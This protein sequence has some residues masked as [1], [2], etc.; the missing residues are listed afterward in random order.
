[1]N[2]KDYLNKVAYVK[3]LD[4][5]NG[6]GDPDF[7]NDCYFSKFDDSYITHVG[8]ED[9]V[10]FLA[11]REITDELTHG[12]GFSPKENKWFGW[13]HRAIYGFEVG[14]TCEK[15]SCH[16]NA[17]NKDDFIESVMA[18]WGDEQYHEREWYEEGT[19]RYK[20][21]E[22]VESPSDG[23]ALVEKPNSTTYGD[24]M[25][26]VWIYSLY[27][28]KV[29]NE[30]LRGTESKQFTEFPEKW[31]RGEWTAKTMEDAKQMAVDFNEGVS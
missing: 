13:S 3:E 8:M 22:Y 30:A 6:S 10:E 21:C 31:G 1:M 11:D 26:G 7:I 25:K 24:E 9:T 4:Q 12:V 20:F 2:T 17:S 23:M 5:S 29:P 15:G 16:Y 14:S 27:N 18:F 19:H 28:D